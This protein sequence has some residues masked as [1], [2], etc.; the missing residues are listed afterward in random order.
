MTSDLSN[1]SGTEMILAH[2]NVLRRRRGGALGA[3]P[4]NTFTTLRITASEWEG[5]G[6]YHLPNAHTARGA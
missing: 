6:V 3:Q 5:I 4:S 2:E 1:N